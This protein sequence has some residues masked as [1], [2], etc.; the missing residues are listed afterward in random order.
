MKVLRSELRKQQQTPKNALL[1][2]F[3][4]YTVLNIVFMFIIVGKV[5]KSDN[6]LVISRWYLI[7]HWR[8]IIVSNS[9]EK[10]KHSETLQATKSRHLTKTGNNRHNGAWIASLSVRMS[11]MMNLQKR[12]SRIPVSIYRLEQCI[13][14]RKFTDGNLHFFGLG[15]INDDAKNFYPSIIFL[16]YSATLILNDVLC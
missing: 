6:N 7:N 12:G 14:Y 1:K 13:M 10:I 5:V 8:F 11:A 15:V 3:L 4:K 2:H 9:W 16:T